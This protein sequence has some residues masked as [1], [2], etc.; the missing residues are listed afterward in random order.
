[1]PADSGKQVE[2]GG[3]DE[4]PVPTQVEPALTPK[5]KPREKE[6]VPPTLK[7]KAESPLT[8]FGEVCRE[9]TVRLQKVNRALP[10]L[11]AVCLEN[12]WL[13]EGQISLEE[14]GEERLKEFLLPQNWE[15][16]MQEMEKLAK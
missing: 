7:K 9:I 10:D 2:Q 3:G 15:V 5:K 12:N 13:D 11:V 16:L 8:P 6:K 1:L 14:I 4:T